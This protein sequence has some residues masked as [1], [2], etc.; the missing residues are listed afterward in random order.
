MGLKANGRKQPVHPMLEMRSASLTQRGREA[1]LA[2]AAREQAKERLVV[3][4][5][6]RIL[7]VTQYVDHILFFFLRE[8]A[9]PADVLVLF[10]Q[11][12]D[13]TRRNSAR[14]RSPLPRR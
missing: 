14:P 8:L 1:L 9:Q 11:E 5:K 10:E 12:N 7:F 6:I 3:N 2:G 4:P 13:W